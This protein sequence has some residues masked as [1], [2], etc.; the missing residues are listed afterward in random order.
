MGTTPTTLNITT[1][2]TMRTDEALRT[3]LNSEEMDALKAIAKV[4]DRSVC[5]LVRIAVREF[6]AKNAQPTV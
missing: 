4:Q 2:K 6:I 3:R 5:A 1:T